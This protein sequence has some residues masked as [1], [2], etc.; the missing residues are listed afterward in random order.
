MISVLPFV[1]KN[2]RS[3]SCS[4]SQHFFK[5]FYLMLPLNVLQRASNE[6]LHVLKSTLCVRVTQVT[7]P[8]ARI[9]RAMLDSPG[10]QHLGTL[11]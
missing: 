1:L 8:K 7:Y 9:S 3:L 5:H 6:F 2:N 10:A 11:L 4:V